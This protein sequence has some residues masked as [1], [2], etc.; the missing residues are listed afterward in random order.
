M[1]T[2]TAISQQRQ[3]MVCIAEPSHA[4]PSV[5]S[6]LARSAF[7]ALHFGDRPRF[8][9]I[10]APARSENELATEPTPPDPAVLVVEGKGQLASTSGA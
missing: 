5:V 9:Q 2:R 6:P 4:G 8:E 1:G 7:M 3:V 10:L